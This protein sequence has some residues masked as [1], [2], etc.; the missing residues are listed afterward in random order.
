MS[1]CLGGNFSTTFVSHR[2]KILENFGK[3]HTAE[4][5]VCE[6][7]GHAIVS[8]FEVWSNRMG[9]CS[10]R[11][12]SRQCIR[13]V[14]T[15]PCDEHLPGGGLQHHFRFASRVLQCFFSEPI[16]LA[17]RSRSFT[18]FQFFRAMH[19]RVF[20][21]AC[22]SPKSRTERLSHKLVHAEPRFSPLRLP[23]FTLYRHTLRPPPQ[24][25]VG[26]PN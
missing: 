24:S 12:S 17:S 26:I 18:Q 13:D 23:R 7:G 21:Q 1:T 8:R 3:F 19:L 16:S 5:A 10:Y 14:L 2:V 11:T 22:P 9:P 20:S 4:R 6:C 25:V 15:R